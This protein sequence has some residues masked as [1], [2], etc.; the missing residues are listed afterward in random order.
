MG[1]Y[2][3]GTMLVKGHIN[4]PI[5]VLYD[6]AFSSMSYVDGKVYGD[7]CIHLSYKPYDKLKCP[8]EDQDIEG[9]FDESVLEGSEVEF[10]LL[11]RR[12]A[13]GQSALRLKS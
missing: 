1:C 3:H 9:I 2:N 6:Y 4:C 7:E 5:I 10:K 13:S 11:S 8:E 12:V